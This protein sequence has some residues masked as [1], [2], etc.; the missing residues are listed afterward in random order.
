MT[1]AALPGL[2]L[3]EPA[4]VLAMLILIEGGVLWL[5]TQPYAQWLF[6]YLP[7]MFWIYF[8][9]M[10]CNTLGLLPPQSAVYDVIGTYVLPASLLL[11]LIPVD[12]KSI[13]RL[14][15]IALAIMLAGS[16]GTFVGGPIVT[17]LY[18]GML[19]EDAWRSV[20]ILSASWIGGSANMAAVKEATGTPDSAMNLAVVVD[21]LIP[22]AWMGL[23]VLLSAFQKPYDRW[24]RSRESMIAELSERAK[25]RAAQPMPVNLP[26]IG[27]MAAVA[28]IGSV[29]ALLLAGEGVNLQKA[30]DVKVL[31]LKASAILLAS[32]AG[33]G[34]SFTPL[35]RLD[36]QGATHFGNLLL[37]LLLAT[38]GAKASLANLGAAPWL[39]AAGATW[40]VIHAAVLV[41]AGRLL[42][43]PMALLATAS[44][45][46]IGGPASAPVI[47]GVYHPALPTVGLLMALLGNIIGT[48]AGWACYWV[49]GKVAGQ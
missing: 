15:P 20:G 27:V 19:P 16:L 33:I 26:G 48:Y 34:L 14:G 18:Q 29:L 1:L 17:A 49:C 5:S 21:T 9:P 43:A 38:F 44:Q 7:S 41:L 8:V 46:N 2:P 24:N 6:K 23:L 45:A 47:A 30:W 35:R 31:D 37:Y 42:R 11:L 12:V 28:V 22:Y 39:L 36:A 10:L 40:I 4:P 3:T 25:V 13:L 32:V